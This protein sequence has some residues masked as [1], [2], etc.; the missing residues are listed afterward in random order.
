MYQFVFNQIERA[1]QQ[2]NRNNQLFE[3]NNTLGHLRENY[4]KNNFSVSSDE[5]GGAISF[6]IKL[7]V[8]ANKDFSDIDGRDKNNFYSTDELARKIGGKS[9]IVDKNSKIATVFGNNTKGKSNLN[10][11]EK[12]DGENFKKIFDEICRLSSQDGFDRF[13]VVNFGYLRNTRLSL[14]KI[15]Q[16]NA[17]LS[18]T[19]DTP[20]TFSPVNFNQP[21]TNQPLAPVPPVAQPKTNQPLAPVP[22]VTQPSSVF[23]KPQNP[24]PNP[25]P[26]PNAILANSITSTSSQNVP[27]NTSVSSTSNIPVQSVP[28]QNIK[29]DSTRSTSSQNL[30]LNTSVS[31]TS[32]ALVPQQQK[33]PVSATPKKVGNVRY[34][35]SPLNLLL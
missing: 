34:Y 29:S 14:S 22:P 20:S 25:N 28:Q 13:V 35:A 15:Q 9:Y 6:G 12:F 33:P 16:N 24:N 2:N 30:P 5:I 3:Q 17:I 21:K 19:S 18:A 32:S 27:L 26:N 1:S 8:F 10:L 31:S 4:K 23:V 7:F 11:S